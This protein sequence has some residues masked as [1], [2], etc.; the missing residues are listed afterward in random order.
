MIREV[1]MFWHVI[2][3]WL[4][5]IVF[6][7]VNCVSI[8]L[9]E[10]FQTL[11]KSGGESVC[12]L[13]NSHQLRPTSAADGAGG[14]LVA[15][16]DQRSGNRI[17]AQK[18]NSA[19]YRLWENNGVLLGTS[20]SEGNPT[21]CNDGTGGAIVTWD[22]NGTIGGIVASRINHEGIVEW[23]TVICN[24]PGEQYFPKIVSDNAGGAIIAWRDGRDPGWDVYAQ[25]I[26]SEGLVKWQTNGKPIRH[27]NQGGWDI[28]NIYIISDGAEGAIICWQDNRNSR[29]GNG[30]DVYCQH[31]EGSGNLRWGS[32]GFSVYGG[33]GDQKR[34]YACSDGSGGV[35]ITWTD[36][37]NGNWD[38]YA[39]RILNSGSKQW[40]GSGVPVCNIA[41]T[42]YSY[43]IVSDGESG[44]IVVWDDDRNGNW[45]VYA[46]KIDFDGVLVWSPSGEPVSIIS[47]S[48][49]YRAQMVSDGSGGA[50]IAWWDYRNA[51]YYDSRSD[52]YAQRINTNGVIQ[53]T[54][55]GVAICARRYD[56]YFQYD[57]DV[58]YNTNNIVSDGSGGAIIAWQDAIN[59]DYGNG[60]DV[61][62]QRINDNLPSGPTSAYGWSDDS[63]TFS[64]ITNSWYN[65]P[66]PYF[67]WSPATSENGIAGY[68]VSFTK[69][70]KDTVDTAIIQ[71]DTTY[72]VQG[73]LDDN[74]AYY[75]RVRAKNNNGYWN[76]AK[77]LF[78]Y[79]YDITPPEAFNLSSPAN[80]GWGNA[81]P[82][83]SWERLSDVGSG[84]SHYQL[85]INNELNKDSLSSNYNQTPASPLSE[86]FHT[87]FVKAI[88]K[89]GNE[90]K[91]NQTWS[92][93]VD[94]TS[95]VKFDITSPGDNEWTNNLQP[96][97]TWQT[98][99]DA[100]SGL[101]KY[102][103]LIDNLIKRDNIPPTTTSST[104]TTKLSNG[105]HIW[106]VQA[107]D[108]VNNSQK[109]NQSW[110][111]KIDNVPPGGEFVNGIKGEYYSNP[112]SD[113]S[114]SFGR[115]RFTRIDA[116]INF[117]WEQGSP[118]YGLQENDFQVRWSGYL[119]A[120]VTGSYL[121]KTTTDDGVKLWIDNELLIDA[122]YDQD[123][124]SHSANKFL[125]GNKWY[126][127][128][129]EYYENERFARA[130]LYWTLPGGIEEIIPTQ[131]LRADPGFELESPDNNSWSNDPTPTFSWQEAFD[132]GI[133]LAKY[134][135]WIDGELIIDDI[136]PGTTSLILNDS[137]ALSSGNHTWF[138]KAFD[139]LD[140]VSQSNHSWTIR[141]DTKSPSAFSLKSPQDSS[142]I[143]FPTPNFSWSPTTD[144]GSGLSHYQLWID[145]NLSADNLTTIAS[146]PG[147]PLSEGYHR[148]FVK[149]IDKVGNEMNSKETWTVI[150]E[151]NP[152]IPFDLASPANGDTTIF[153]KPTLYW[154]PSDDVGSGL[155]KY[156][157]WIDGVLNQNY[158]APADTSIT[159]V[160]PLSNGSHPWFVKAV[161]RAGSNTSSNS[162]WQLFV[163]RDL[164]PPEVNIITPAEGY[165]IK[166]PTFT[167]TGNA[168]DTGGSGVDSVWISIDN[169][170]WLGVT[171]TGTDFSTWAYQWTGYSAGS[172]KVRS[173]AIDRAGNEQEAFS[174]IKFFVNL[175]APTIAS[176]SISP[177]PAKAG[178]IIVTI[179][180][181][182]PDGIDN[183]VSPLVSFRPTGSTAVYSVNQTS[184]TKGTWTGVGVVMADLNNG[185]AKLIV[186]GV[187]DIYGNIMD[188]DSSSGDFIIDTVPPTIDSVSV[189]PDPAKDGNIYIAITFLEATSG[190]DT[191]AHPTITFIPMGGMP[192]SV[193]QTAFDSQTKN[194]SG[195]GSISSEMADGVATILV[196]G[197]KDLAGNQ[198]KENKDAKRFLIDVTPP[199]AFDL[200]SPEDS[201]WLNVTLPIFKWNPSSDATS[202]LKGYDL[203]INGE[204]AIANISAQETNQQLV[205]PLSDGEYLWTVD[206]YDSA[207]NETRAN[208]E[209]ILSIDTTPPISEVTNLTAGQ[210][211]IGPVFIIE[212]E[213]N[214]GFG[215]SKGIGVDSVFISVDG[216]YQWRPATSDSLDYFRW[217][218]VWSSFENQDYTI[219][220]KAIDKLG[221]EEIPSDGLVVTDVEERISKVIPKEYCL[222]QNYPNPFNPETTIRFQLPKKE[223]IKIVIYN[224]RGQKIRTLVDKMMQPGYFK[225]IWD[226]KDD[227][228][229][230][231]S[232][233]VYIYQMHAGRY[234]T[235][236]K[237]LLLK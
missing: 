221:N 188:P 144:D 73:P 212:G 61:Y 209:H 9:A 70:S 225:I 72:N 191:T 110:K 138:I 219:K 50:I 223:N 151:W 224:Q 84:I 116:N 181:F 192:V 2:K 64:L 104:P 148:W 100:G 56:Q 197:A 189:N 22:D 152:P 131:K 40:G 129:M 38:V 60:W 113:V 180:F 160:S 171:N 39:Q 165:T 28:D 158:I 33:S 235:K 163:N 49:Q 81:L 215:A 222:F 135:L 103:L 214:D 15:W 96:L 183:S 216:G 5:A 164:T 12:S 4:L 85:W 200:L 26:N 68:A 173:R 8:T 93:R 11:W 76:V 79:R 3:K 17:Y 124:V 122:W 220:S 62:A 182:D 106:C 99:S 43:D 108:N 55:N 128:K 69:D 205:S 35:I 196:K 123:T 211:V 139:N 47:S 185:F 153:D 134:Q 217:I 14:L 67:T 98:S 78:I 140:N 112:G 29:Y 1:I 169:G 172:H 149:A 190:I 186:S 36:S 206:A 233:G 162:T 57:G 132:Q 41:G 44:A 126:E 202:G 86:S 143:K 226:A 25:R 208:K 34:P 32:N 166:A 213:A 92:V 194:W 53:W 59:W 168:S 97:F 156:E 155:E 37:R 114:P 94:A 109:S 167:M 170:P 19:G 227:R 120:P 87:W 117:N 175:S 90:K 207:G 193:I 130:W 201:T 174:A 102:Q 218:Y 21:I 176:S 198:M 83:F 137:L 10:E 42:Q 236:K 184:F 141:V 127:L 229:N 58:Y 52:I 24:A 13:Q 161:D 177:N 111:I 6:I 178:D 231:V 45:D 66:N 179:K 91:S 48:H 157:L 203:F 105:E 147:T 210:D 119:H 46:Q 80:G 18:L 30:W 20:G 115:L 142:F 136:P 204:L 234:Q 101:E 7:T 146:A 65:Y 88:D 71:T 121:F 31:I 125:V 133:G 107:I 154:H 82:R 145:N 27:Y 150:G 230:K 118:G 237:M 187:M 54:E 232:S 16:Q 95:P 199:V 228:G 74:S 75:L 195:I 89:A 23:T 63:R 77:T 51:S 159:P